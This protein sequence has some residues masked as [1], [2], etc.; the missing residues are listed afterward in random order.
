LEAAYFAATGGS[1]P[2]DHPAA[3]DQP[4][5]VAQS[6]IVVGSGFAAEPGMGGI[7]PI[8]CGSADADP[9]DARVVF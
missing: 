9:T 8:R 6:V 1:R 4:A 5:P 7:A 2:V 3:V